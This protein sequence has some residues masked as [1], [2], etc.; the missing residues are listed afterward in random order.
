MIPR[1]EKIKPLKVHPNT[2]HQYF[3]KNLSDII[4]NKDPDWL[5]SFVIANRGPWR[6]WDDF[7]RWV[8]Y[9]YE[10]ENGV[11]VIKLA[12]ETNLGMPSR[13][14]LYDIAD[15]VSETMPEEES[16]VYPYASFEEAQIVEDFGEDR[17]MPLNYLPNVEGKEIESRLSVLWERRG[18]ADVVEVDLIVDLGNSRTVAILLEAP[19]P[20]EN[21]PFDK[22]AK[23]LRFLPRGTQY[24]PSQDSAEDIIESYL[25]LHRPIFASMEPPASE[26]KISDAWEAYNDPRTGR[27]LFRKK[28]ILPHT[29]VELSPALIGGGRS[30]DGAARILASLSLDHDAR[31]S[32]S[33]PKRYA[34]DERLVGEDGTTFWKQIPNRTDPDIPPDFF[35]DLRGLIRV[36]MDPGGLDWDIENPP[37]PEDFRGMPFTSSRP[38]YPRRDA[39][40]WF[41]L[42]IIEQAYRQ[43]NAPEYLKMSENGSLPR[44]LRNIRVTY[45]AGWT[46]QEREN[47]LKQWQRAI[48]L[49]TLTRFE[50]HRPVPLT[51]RG[52]GGMR[53]R[54]AEE[55]MD[56]AV[57]SQLPILFADLKALGGDGTVWSNLYGIQDEVVV[58]NVDIGGGT[59]DLAI[60][61]YK[62]SRGAGDQPRG[63]MLM[64]KTAVS[65][66]PQLL[67]R[68]G[69]KIAG[70]S[71][72]KTIIERILIPTWIRAGG[73]DQYADVPDALEWI[74]RL[75]KAPSHSSFLG[76]DPKASQRL[77]RVARLVFIPLVNEWLTRLGKQGE[78]WEPLEVAK[79]VD[80]TTV[81][82]LNE[83]VDR[84]I[85]GKTAQGNYYWRGRAFPIED[86]FLKCDR[87]KITD[88][89]QDTFGGLFDSLTPLLARF[90]CHLV[91]VSG[92]PSE[93]T[94]V[95]DMIVEA[96]PILPQRIIQVKNFPAGTWYPGS[97]FDGRIPDAKTCTV[98]GAALYQDICNGALDSFS[99]KQPGETVFS[100]Q[101]YWGLIWP[102]ML[103]AD[104]FARKNLLFSPADYPGPAKD[105]DTITM[106]R[107]FDF[108]P[109]NT[110]IGRQNLRSSSIGPDPVYQL[111]WRPR[112]RVAKSEV[113]VKL[114]L[115]WVSRLG[116]GEYLELVPGS[117]EP[118]KGYEFVNPDDVAL[119]LN[120]MMDESFW[121]DD[122]K[123]NVDLARMG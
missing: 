91:I 50:D 60:I 3:R 33:S 14:Q 113:Y 87:Q 96:F 28:R 37:D 53:P 111:Q 1:K 93:L 86:T 121:L 116:A 106:E 62:I 10:I 25:I 100:R 74:E 65:L 94:Q 92:K 77:M 38:N 43:I 61:N 115:R 51:P 108:F 13:G 72:V 15:T 101:Y 117:V 40:C 21:Q 75:F 102:T 45:P 52:D 66:E 112:D 48:N 31:F 26:D 34:W 5:E 54:L 47:Y 76:V 110:R 19:A 58:M 85:R 97:M 78:T 122:P 11:P 32:L 90:N 68:Y 8:R 24:E 46:A 114:K 20:G 89:I 64:K 98:V 69:S 118:S 49:F 35:D 18:G 59:T 82:D 56:E 36:F 120:T 23:S 9:Q 17:M 44:R 73:L 22:R 39:I 4:P 2:G 16:E 42:S 103:P 104:F 81:N 6:V 27:R 57:C 7:T 99:I 41:A 83:L 70:D 67:F 12:I 95:R 80:P 107:A 119:R 30:P 88:C 71:L 84:T 55:N 79:Y 109:L 123:L 105:R 29:F 63:G